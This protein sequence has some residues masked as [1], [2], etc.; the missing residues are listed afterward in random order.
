MRISPLPKQYRTKKLF[1][2]GGLVYRNIRNVIPWLG[3]NDD[4]PLAAKS[5]T[6]ASQPDSA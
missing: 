2:I 4:V 3:K 1:G 6:I 5:K